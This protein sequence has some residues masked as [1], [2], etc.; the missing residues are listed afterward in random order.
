M[1]DINATFTWRLARPAS[2]EQPV[3]HAEFDGDSTDGRTVTG[4]AIMNFVES[5]PA[6]WDQILSPLWG[7]ANRYQPKSIKLEIDGIGVFCAT[8]DVIKRTLLFSE[9][10]QWLLEAREPSLADF[11]ANAARL[12]EDEPI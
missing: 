8:G 5:S 11:L 10:G 12:A 9:G 4:N 6:V 1:L 2:H 3:L 7:K